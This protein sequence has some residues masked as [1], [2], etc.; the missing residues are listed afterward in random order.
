MTGAAH[1]SPRAYARWTA[2]RRALLLR[3][4]EEGLPIPRIAARLGVSDRKVHDALAPLRAQ[5][6]IETR[7]KLRGAPVPI[8]DLPP[9]GMDADKAFRDMATR[10][11]R[12]LL[13]GYRRYFMKGG[14]A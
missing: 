6:V 11:S 8:A 4:Y 13:A 1:E 7:R 3:L 2:E 12:A 9:I 10:G 5:G 14:R